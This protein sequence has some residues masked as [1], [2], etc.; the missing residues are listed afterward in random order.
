M[1]GY[2]AL[3]GLVLCSGGGFLAVVLDLRG[4]MV[5]V[6]NVLLVTFL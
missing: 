4:G 6:G 2:G 5:R 1:G 3:G